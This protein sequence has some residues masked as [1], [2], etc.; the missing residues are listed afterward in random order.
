MLLFFLMFGLLPL[1]LLK[2]VI[3]WI[4]IK[5]NHEFLGCG[6]SRIEICSGHIETDCACATCGYNLKT[7]AAAGMCPE[8]GA[9]YYVNE[10]PVKREA[11]F[12]PF[13]VALVVCSLDIGVTMVLLFLADWYGLPWGMV[14]AGELAKLAVWGG[15]FR[16]STQHFQDGN[17]APFIF[18]STGA[19]GTLVTD[20]LGAGLMIAIIANGPKC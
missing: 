10:M 2:V 3:F 1:S 16:L 20:A 4:I 13:S 17:R 11:A 7:L 6:I 8:C 14:A 9:A 18:I 19:I 15:A 12:S 5:T